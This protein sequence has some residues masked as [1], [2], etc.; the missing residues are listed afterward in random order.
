MDLLA[1]VSAS[2]MT[3]PASTL[4]CRTRRLRSVT[5]F[6]IIELAIVTVVIG[7]IT[8]IAVPGYRRIQRNTR[9]GVLNNDFRVFAGAFQQ[10]NTVNGAWPVYSA[11]VG[12]FPPGMEQYL[13]QSNW[14]KPTVFSGYYNWDYNIMHN[15]AKV[16]AAIAIYSVPG[17]TFVMTQAEMQQFD[18]LYDDGNLG[19]G[20]FQMGYQ[21]SPVYVIE[22]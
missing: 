3:L 17:S 15:G 1:G 7:L 6:T 11:T 5:A 19:T 16:K 4:P 9:F 21:N 22:K 12:T 14:T 18:T 8:G 20:Y 2:W 10:Y 13:R